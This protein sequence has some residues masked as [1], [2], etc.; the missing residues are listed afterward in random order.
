MAINSFGWGYGIYAGNDG[1]YWIS[2]LAGRKTMPPPVVFSLVNPAEDTF[3]TAEVCK[4]IMDKAADPM[5]LYQYLNEQ[6][7]H[8]IYI[9]KR[10]GMFSPEA[11]E[12]SPLFEAI[13]AYQGTYVFRLASSG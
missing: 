12:E 7:I 13:Y 2:P 5:A 3:R 4:Q 6:G 11:L 1:G 9:G 8:Y 10:G